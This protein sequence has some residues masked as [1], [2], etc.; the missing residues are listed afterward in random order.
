ELDLA[1]ALPNSLGIRQVS[2]EPDCN[3]ASTCPL[4]VSYRDAGPTK[5][6]LVSKT[7]LDRKLIGVT[8]RDGVGR[9]V[10]KHAAQAEV[11]QA[12][13]CGSEANI[14]LLLARYPAG[15]HAGSAEVHLT[16]QS[17]LEL[18]VHGYSTLIPLLNRSSSLLPAKM[19]MG[20][21][22]GRL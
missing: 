18:L 1:G 7:Q 6:N 12:S 15:S 9:Q 21:L 16:S 10:E 8:E 5:E 22:R 2:E 14:G 19:R 17:P 13:G 20:G 11:A 3:A 4:F